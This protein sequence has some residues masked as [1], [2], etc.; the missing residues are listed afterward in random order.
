MSAIWDHASI[1][2]GG[3]ITSER[4]EKALGY[5]FWSPPSSFLLNTATGSVQQVQDRD[6]T[7]LLRDRTPALAI[8]SNAAP[9]HL[10]WKFA[11]RFDEPTVA[12]TTVRIKNY[13]VVY[14][15]HISRYGSVP[16][17]MVKSPGTTVQLKLL[18][19]TPEQTTLMHD[20]E[21]LGAD[22]AI[23]HVDTEDIV[24]SEAAAPFVD[25]LEHVEF[26][27]ALAGPL[28]IEGSPVALSDISAEG[29]VWPARGQHDMLSLLAEASGHTSIEQM[30]GVVTAGA[31]AWEDFNWRMR[32]G[33]FL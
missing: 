13:E 5:P 26:Y 22:Y 19:S 9:E 11:D 3:N 28:R 10:A 23:G 14:A 24:S 4:L 8:G 32:E 27:E 29:R 21:S 12:A 15:T 1:Y 17:T 25:G 7:A 31:G 30:L 16:A 2:S 20:S 18:W 33:E 6:L